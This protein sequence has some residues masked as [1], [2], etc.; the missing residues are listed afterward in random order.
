MT[1]S[2]RSSRVAAATAA[3]AVAPPPP[4][5]LRAPAKKA[6]KRK[7]AAV[8]AS[9]S[10]TP[11]RKIKRTGLT[12]P[13]ERADTSSPLGVIDPEC[14]VN[15][16]IVDLDGHPCDAMLALVDPA[17]N[18]D[19]YFILQLIQKDDEDDAYLVYTRWGRTGTKGQ[20]LEQEFDD[21]EGAKT[22]F[23]D[24]F[25]Q[26]TALEWDERN[27]EPTVGNKYRFVTQDFSQKLNAYGGAK[28]EYW[29]DDRIDG[30]TDGWYEYE[31]AASR[32]VEQLF[33]EH[34]GNPNLSVRIVQ[35]GSYEYSVDMSTMTQTNTQTDKARRIRR[36]PIGANADDEDDKEEE[37][38][39]GVTATATAAATVTAAPTTPVKASRTSNRKPKATPVTP[40]RNSAPSTPV[41]STKTATKKAAIA[42][43]SAVS[44]VSPNPKAA[45]AAPKKSGSHPVD[46]DIS[47]A[48]KVASHYEVVQDSDSDLWY[49]A[50]LNQ[51]NI[52]NNN[53]KYY[54]LQILKDAGSGSSGPYYTWF[55][56]GRVGEA[57]RGSSST[58]DGPFNTE[59]AAKKVFGKKY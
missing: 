51:C 35:S 22:C 27:N 33:H 4:P 46:A 55:K 54:R 37:D 56:W 49:D 23:L 38:A 17:K 50:V 20:A 42:K 7:A 24:K 29:V 5:A 19:K 31:D 53:N 41:P 47:V 2:R 12:S 59:S 32:Q 3:A 6:T 57:A 48:G 10:S 1:G 34:S 44:I 30:K 25:R 9:S 39:V 45:A 16:T 14:N 43:G 15:G 13:V 28:W 26:K 52:G 40:S 8:A 58:W 11:V 18:M 36:R 21:L